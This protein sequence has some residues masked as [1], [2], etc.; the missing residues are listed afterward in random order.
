[1][2]DGLVIVIDALG[3]LISALSES[4]G[5]QIVIATVMTSIALGIRDGSRESM[6]FTLARTNRSRG[7]TG[8]TSGLTC[9]SLALGWCGFQMTGQAVLTELLDRQVALAGRV[10]HAQR[11]NAGF[12]LFIGDGVDSEI[13]VQIGLRAKRKADIGNRA[14]IR[15]LDAGH[16]AL[17]MVTLVRFAPGM[18]VAPATRGFR[19]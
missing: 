18:T 3:R 4:H 2:C 10:E 13:R 1:M 17:D 5:A 6:N 15:G 16:H 7:M 8:S 14:R 19:H 9:V 12:R 11:C